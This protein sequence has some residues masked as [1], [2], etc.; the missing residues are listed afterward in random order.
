MK[1]ILI[2]FFTL[3]LFSKVMANNISW[4]FPPVTLSSASLAASDPQIA[5][6]GNGNAAAAWVENGFIKASV[7]PIGMSWSTAVTISNTGASF[8]RIVSDLNGNITAVWLESGVVK[9]ASKPSSGSWSSST[10]LSST[11]ATS[12]HIA[13]DSVGDVVAVWAR[14]GNVESSTKIFGASW[15][16]RVTITSTSAASPHVAMGGTG[17]NRTATVVWT[18]VSGTKNVVYASTKSVIAS[19]WTESKGSWSAQTLISNTVQNAGYATVALDS[20]ANAVA[21]WYAYNVDTTGTIFS[22]VNVQSSYLPIGG[23]WKSPTVVSN[24]GIRNPATLYARVAFDAIGNAIALWNMSFDDRTFNIQSAVLPLRGDWT[25]PTDIVSSNLFAYETDLAVSSLGDALAVYMFYNG[26][27]MLIQS[28]ESDFTGLE[29]NAWAIPINLSSGANHGFP[30][31]ASTL[32]GNTINAAVVWL[33]TNGTVNT[34]L[35][36]TGSRSVLLPPTSLAASQSSTSFGGVFTEYHNTVTWTA[37]AS[38]NIV[39]Y[40]VFR[41]GTPIA[42]VAANVLAYVDNN[43]VQGQA[44]TYGVA[45]V[46][47]Q[48]SQSTIPTAHY[49]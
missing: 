10:A 13:V 3:L 27:F 46:D 16:A 2:T 33:S 26:S 34:V 36:T 8:P 14:S 21:V 32:T 4:S 12:P 38:P 41:N 30:H 5:I 39:G 40:I 44:V 6:D 1:K 23:S 17:T 35:A 24:P 42:E 43:R 18:G 47:N 45:A 9:A 28:S 15:Q 19:S 7:K 48:G 37:S 20:N 31:V 29:S 11:T 22:E 25:T 49:P